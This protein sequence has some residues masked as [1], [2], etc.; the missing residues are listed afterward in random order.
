MLTKVSGDG[1][2]QRRV[3]ASLNGT[4]ALTS[5]GKVI[6]TEILTKYSHSCKLWE[7][8]KDSSSYEDWKATHECPINHKGSVGSMEVAGMIKMFGRSEREKKLGYTT[9]IGDG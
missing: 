2:W 8:K 3:F 9:Y 7:H 6:N 1:A 5:G 4:V